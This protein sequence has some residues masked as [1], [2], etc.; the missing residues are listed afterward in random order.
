M[1]ASFENDPLGMPTMAC[2]PGGETTPRAYSEAVFFMVTVTGP[3]MEGTTTL[4]DVR[5][6]SF[7]RTWN[8]LQPGVS[9][10]TPA[11]DWDRLITGGFQPWLSD[12]P[13]SKALRRVA[14]QRS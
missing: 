2:V 11:M 9:G 1:R 8:V 5:K 3:S 4:S 10:A 7:G 13:A 14:H 6:A 12:E